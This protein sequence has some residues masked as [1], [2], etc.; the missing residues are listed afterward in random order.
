M[1]SKHYCRLLL[2][3]LV[4]AV[5]GTIDFSLIGSQDNQVRACVIQTENRET[6]RPV[7]FLYRLELEIEDYYEAH[8]G[9]QQADRAQRHAGPIRELRGG[10]GRRGGAR[11]APPPISLIFHF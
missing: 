5:V 9:L 10:S 2:L 7:N 8:L 4:A 11:A 1:G 3:L 6:T